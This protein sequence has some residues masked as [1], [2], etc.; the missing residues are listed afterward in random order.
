VY[1]DFNGERYK[2][3]SDR[4]IVVAVKTGGVSET[5]KQAVEWATENRQI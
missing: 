2:R 3:Q 1:G 5:L 4:I